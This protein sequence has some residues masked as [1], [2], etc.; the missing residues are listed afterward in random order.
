ME[1]LD[2]DCDN[3]SIPLVKISDKNKA[4]QFGLEETPAVL[5]FKHQIPGTTTKNIEMCSHYIA[6]QT[7]NC[8]KFFFVCP[9][10]LPF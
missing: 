4:L 2:D 10:W 5:Y 6:L 7:E 3:I 1:Q 8:L 9:I